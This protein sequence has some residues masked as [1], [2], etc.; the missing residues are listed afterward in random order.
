MKPRP[1]ARTPA[2]DMI[3]TEFMPQPRQGGAA[4]LN[5]YSFDTVIAQKAHWQ[6]KSAPV[7]RIECI[8]P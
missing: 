1:A 2:L 3:I 7:S 5:I 8:T 6:G 4:T